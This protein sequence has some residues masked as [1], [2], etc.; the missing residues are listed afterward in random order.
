MYQ[1]GIELNDVKRC[2]GFGLD[3][4]L[5]IHGKS[6]GISLTGQINKNN[7]LKRNGGKVGKYRHLGCKCQRRQLPL[8]ESS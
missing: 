4:S 1:T 6:N 5:N 8:N 7:C 2:L 3:L